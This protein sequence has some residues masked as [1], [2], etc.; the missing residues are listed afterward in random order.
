MS[1][2]ETVKAQLQAD[3]AAANEVTG[4]ADT[5]LHAAV[6]S[7]IDGFGQAEE[8]WFSVWGQLYTKEIFSEET[9]GVKSYAY[10]QCAN[11]E[12]VILPNCQSIG[13]TWCFSEN[14]NLKT[15][16][17]GRVADV[18]AATCRECPRLETLEIGSIGNPVSSIA[19][20]AFYNPGVA[21]TI[22]IYVN[23]TVLADIPEAVSSTAPWGAPN[24]TIIYRSTTTGEVI[25]V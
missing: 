19:P 7:L 18:P 25:E 23:G 8:S 9:K 1:T 12:S 10:Y 14:P 4:K 2:P 15:A 21:F 17:L 13:G 16:K 11:L 5:T 3:I 20:A 22:T 6:S 24:A